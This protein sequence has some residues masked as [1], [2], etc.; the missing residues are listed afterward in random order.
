MKWCAARL[1]KD[2]Q[3]G[4]KRVVK[5]KMKMLVHSAFQ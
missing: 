5:V 3:V 4:V 1:M 2:T